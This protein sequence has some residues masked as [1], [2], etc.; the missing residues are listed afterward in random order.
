MLQYGKNIVQ[1]LIDGIKS[2]IKKVRDVVGSLVDS[3]KSKITG[4][5]GI[6]SPSK[7]MIEFGEDT[8]EGFL[9]GLR[10]MMSEVSTQAQALANAAIPEVPKI[11]GNSGASNIGTPSTSTHYHFAPGSI[12]IPAKDIAEMNSVTEFFTRFKQVARAIGGVNI[13]IQS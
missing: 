1:G 13:A 6:S 5:L 10:S 11:A 9:I 7:V 12:V 2:M 8:G 3:I 4:A